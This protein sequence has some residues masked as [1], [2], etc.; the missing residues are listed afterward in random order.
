MT[1]PERCTKC[2][3]VATGYRYYDEE[4]GR[5]ECANCVVAERDRL[6]ARLET[7]YR[8]GDV[9]CGEALQMTVTVPHR[10]T[11]QADI[12]EAAVHSFRAACTSRIAPATGEGE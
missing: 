10:V 11:Q 4:T 3:L 2:G 12:L 6:K 7:I 9:L 8:A 1:D 5:Y